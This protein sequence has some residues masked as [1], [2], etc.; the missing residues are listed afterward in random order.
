MDTNINGSARVQ[1]SVALLDR[2]WGRPK[3]SVDV[4]VDHNASG[5]AD[6]INAMQRRMVEMDRQQAA[7]DAQRANIIEGEIVAERPAEK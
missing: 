4:K 5:I 2:G 1:A 3:Q 6:A 7:I